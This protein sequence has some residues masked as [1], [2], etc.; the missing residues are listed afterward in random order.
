[1]NSV[2]HT[3]HNS[4]TSIWPF[5]GA[6]SSSSIYGY[7]RRPKTPKMSQIYAKLL[8]ICMLY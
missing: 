7:Y 8:V 5:I 2:Q 3:H 4:F 6:L 1:M